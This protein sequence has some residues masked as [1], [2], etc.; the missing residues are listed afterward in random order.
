M[1]RQVQPKAS[2]LRLPHVDRK[3]TA[4][5]TP[6]PTPT[7]HPIMQQTPFMATNQLACSSSSNALGQVS[8][9]PSFG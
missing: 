9:D 3:A 7:T 5:L 4:P 2:P 8:L 6:W 1:Q